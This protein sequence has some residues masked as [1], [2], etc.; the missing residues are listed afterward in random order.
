MPAP[1][2]KIR[3][4]FP[5][6]GESAVA[7]LLDEGWSY[8]SGDPAFARTVARRLGKRNS[9]GAHASGYRKSPGTSA[10]RLKRL[11]TSQRRSE[12]VPNLVHSHSLPNC[13]RLSGRSRSLLSNNVD[14]VTLLN[15]PL[16]N[17]H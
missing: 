4:S 10:K 14:P 2:R 15:R 17:Q 1:P 7:Q 3:L 5:A 12:L 9:A 11:G 13:L 16:K 6:T 8:R